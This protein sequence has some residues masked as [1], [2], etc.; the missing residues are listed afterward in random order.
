MLLVLFFVAFQ[1]NAQDEA[2]TYKQ[3]YPK[4]EAALQNVNHT[5]TWGWDKKQKHLFVEER[6]EEKIIALQLNQRVKRAIF[7]DDNSVVQNAEYKASSMKKFTELVG[8]CGNYQSDD[9]FYSDAKI[10]V[11]NFNLS[12][13]GDAVEFAY[14]KRY[15]DVKY[16]TSVYFTDVFPTIN[17][18]ITFQVPDFVEVEL[19][20]FNFAGF[21]IQKKQSRNE[22]DKMTVY[23]Y[24][25][26]DLLPSGEE[27]IKGGSH[28][29]PHI[30]VL[31]KSYTQDGSKTTLISNTDELY[32]WY[33]SLTKGVEGN[34]SELKPL[35]DKLI[36]GK[37]AD[38]E[39]VKAIYYWVQDNIRYIAFED[40]LA[41][42]R[43]AKADEVYKNKYGDCKGMANLVKNML[44]VA[45]YDARLTWIGTSRIAYDYSIPSLAVDNHM[46]CTLL[47]GGKQYFLDP[48]EKYCPLNEY[49]ERI[50]GRPVMIENGEKYILSNVPVL[51]QE[52]N[53]VEIEQNFQL[54]G[55]KLIGNSQA[56]YNGEKKGNLLYYVH[57][58]EKTSRQDL[59][60]AVAGKDKNM[61]IKNLET[62]NLD[63][64]DKPLIVKSELELANQ[65]S[66]F[67]N[68]TYIDLDWNKEFADYK[69][70]KDRN[71]D[72]ILNSK[73]L[74]KTKIKL[75]LPKGYK[76]K[77]VP[78]TL[79]VNNAN[80][81]IKVG[82]EQKNEEIIYTKEISI[83]EGLIKKQ[84][85]EAWNK[86]IDALKKLYNDRVIL[87][88]IK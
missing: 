81:V 4:K 47:L 35:V 54:E 55:E 3:R 69:I 88:K 25:I 43:P 16:F 84:D 76:V 71:F 83:P 32:R 12:M 78:N 45:G 67:D 70:E 10:C 17:Q 79:N 2:Q 87:E 44:K 53:L 75:K 38:E 13:I 58:T 64:R 60:N 80:F 51:K 26:T 65:V 28:V 57:H 77:Y 27:R 6:N 72:Y 61:N 22:R 42:F 46:I 49:A 37:T 82:F 41:G 62:I 15:N 24:A 8:V 30:L 33:S 40:G 31:T 23:E 14:I 48:T 39:K 73:I 50:Q 68:E 86:A 66:I 34:A 63:D 21:K 29:Y 74:N 52:R 18:K 1:A 19:K 5:Y 7:Y 56:T 9:I 59:L 36:A 85:F 20:E 11:Y